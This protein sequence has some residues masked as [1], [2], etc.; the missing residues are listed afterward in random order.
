[1]KQSVISY[2]GFAKCLSSPDNKQGTSGPASV[3]ELLCDSR[4]PQGLLRAALAPSVPG[5]RLCWDAGMTKP[6]LPT[7]GCQQHKHLSPPRCSLFN[8][9]APRCSGI[10][11]QFVCSKVQ[12]SAEIF[13][14][15]CFLSLLFLLCTGLCKGAV[16]G[17]VLLP[18]DGSTQLVSGCLLV[19]SIC[20]SQA[21]GRD[22][23]VGFHHL[24]PLCQ[25]MKIL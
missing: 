22:A 15:L 4:V 5:P 25:A 12:S 9:Y 1:M 17:S 10:P 21:Q 19:T 2:M 13:C 24:N 20:L 11:S 23:L 18:G 7:S 3:K 16:T 6:L 8:I 14:C